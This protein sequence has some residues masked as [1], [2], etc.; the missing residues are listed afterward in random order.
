MSHP[1]IRQLRT[2]VLSGVAAFVLLGGI[3]G[4]VLFVK[5]YLPK[6]VSN[7]LP[8][9]Q[10]IMANEADQSALSAVTETAT[11]I[12][13]KEMYVDTVQE[14]A[15]VYDMMRRARELSSLKFKTKKAAGM[16]A[17][18]EEINGVANDVKK[19]MY[20]VYYVNGQSAQAGISAQ[21]VKPDDKVE[22]KYKKMTN[23]QFLMTNQTPITQ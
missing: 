21:T 13:G 7:V 8:Q 11:L 23:D 5:N 10:A 19:N 20:W 18:V 4:G 15:T 3:I 17:F 12:V 2:M 14:G 6:R 1:T 22:W 9:S 16:D